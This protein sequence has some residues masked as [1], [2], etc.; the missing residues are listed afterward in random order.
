MWTILFR[1][2][3]RNALIPFVTLAG[4]DL[5]SQLGGLIITEV[6]FALPGLGKLTQQAIFNLD[7]PTI[8]GVTLIAAIAIVVMNLIVDLIYAV[9]DPRISYA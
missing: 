6:I 9:L 3:L 7:E 2:V 8:M 5:G 1:H 4:L